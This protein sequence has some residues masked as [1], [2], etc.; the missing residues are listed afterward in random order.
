MGLTQV[1]SLMIKDAA[2]HV[3]DYGAVGDG[4]A[5]DTVAIQA[6]ID[7]VI[8]SGETNTLLITE[9]IYKTTAPLVITEGL[10]FQGEQ[11]S[12]TVLNKGGTINAVHT[13][14]SI[15]AIKGAG[16]VKLADL[17]LSTDTTTFPKTGIS[18]GRESTPS[19]G[20][21][22]FSRIRIQGYFSVAAIYS[23]ASE[24][25]IWDDMY[26]W[27]LGGGAQ[28]TFYSSNT[29]DLSVNSYYSS[30]NV[31]GSFIHCYFLNSSNDV[32]GACVYLELGESM[33]GWNFTSCY[34]IPS[35]GSYV[36]LNNATDAQAI[37]PF[38]F[39][40]TNGERLGPTG[41]PTFGFRLTSSV[42]CNIRGFNI[43]GARMDFQAGATKAQIHLD[44]NITLTAPNVVLQP[45]EAFPY[46]VLTYAPEQI[47]GGI[48]SVD[49]EATLATPT[50]LNSWVNSLGAPYQ[51]V[52]YNRSAEGIIQLYGRVSG[53]TG[54]I[55]TLPV[56]FRP[57]YDTI[58]SAV[59]N[60]TSA[61]ILV[62][63]NGDVSL[64]SGAGPVNLTSVT[65]QAGN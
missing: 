21:H 8:A 30:S 9:G 1:R 2:H 28:H 20:H 44:T 42:P 41:D 36:R 10:I 63:Q 43:I 18:L 64:Y 11:G 51:Q 34:F 14:H 52:K 7:G 47:V 40:A 29:D 61:E 55:M 33:G 22:K 54:V 53:G 5:D 50:L 59:G 38:N 32:D 19:S 39:I 24:V 35:K 27:L 3:R 60:S 15:I 56:K 23:I 17:N 6:G 26:V 62:K 37:G 25:N 16:R 4:V 57:R 65:F 45:P 46:A 13:G 12:S 58:F 48:F 49:R 31:Q